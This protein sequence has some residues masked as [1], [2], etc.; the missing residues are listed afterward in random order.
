MGLAL[1]ALGVWVLG[2]LYVDVW[3]FGYLGSIF[4][5]LTGVDDDLLFLGGEVALR[6]PPALRPSRGLRHEE[7]GGE[8][9][10]DCVGKGQYLLFQKH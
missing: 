6:I 5:W 8:T 3:G 9:N 2:C 7:E 4:G 1:G 10:T